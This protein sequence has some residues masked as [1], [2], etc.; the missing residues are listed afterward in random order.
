MDLYKI[1]Q[2]ERNFGPYYYY[3]PPTS[4]TVPMWEWN[5]LKESKWKIWFD[6]NYSFFSTGTPRSCFKLH[7]FLI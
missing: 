7:I 2:W 3:P 4:S 5:F 6:S 1:L